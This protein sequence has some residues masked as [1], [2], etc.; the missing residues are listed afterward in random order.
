M[1]LIKAN[2]PQQNGHVEALN[3]ER[4]SHFSWVV[5]KDMFHLKITISFNFWSFAT[6]NG[7]SKSHKNRQTTKTNTKKKYIYIKPKNQKR[8]KCPVLSSCRVSKYLLLKRFPR[9]GFWLPLPKSWCHSKEGWNLY[10]YLVFRELIIFLVF[11]LQYISSK[12]YSYI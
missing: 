1:P 5:K 12:A 8:T 4:F 10:L 2:N 3:L 6:R 7:K 9:A 11:F